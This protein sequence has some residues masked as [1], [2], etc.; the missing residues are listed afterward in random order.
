MKKIIFT[1]FQQGEKS[2]LFFLYPFDYVCC[3][4]SD[5]CRIIAAILCLLS[6]I[7]R[8]ASTVCQLL[9]AVFWSGEISC[10]L[11]TRT[12]LGQPTL[13]QRYDQTKKYKEMKFIANQERV[14][15]CLLFTKFFVNLYRKFSCIKESGTI[16]LLKSN[17]Y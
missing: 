3:F 2:F 17:T 15:Y 6:A 8:F 14:I 13:Y 11:T 7:F 16:P 10:K 5:V 9:C 12:P 1:I 4:L